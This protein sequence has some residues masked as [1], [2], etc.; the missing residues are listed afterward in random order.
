MTFGS[1]RL[2]F[3][4]EYEPEFPDRCAICGRESPGASYLSRILYPVWFGMHAL[5]I[6]R[7]RLQPRRIP[8]CTGC[9]R[10][11]LHS[12]GVFGW[13]FLAAIISTVFLSLF[14]LE[15]VVRVVVPSPWSLGFVAVPMLM[16]VAILSSLRWK[17]ADVV[18][19]GDTVE[20]LV[21]DPEYAREFDALNREHLLSAEEIRGKRARRW[22]LARA[23]GGRGRVRATYAATRIG[24]YREFLARFPARCVGC[25]VDAPGSRAAFQ[26]RYSG[27]MW[28]HRAILPN[29]GARPRV[30]CC[31][32]CLSRIQRLRF[33]R[34]TWTAAFLGVFAVF[35][36]EGLVREWI[37]RPWSMPFAAL[38]WIALLGTAIFSAPPI[39][40]TVR[41]DHVEY[42]FGNPTFAREFSKLNRESVVSR[43]PS[44]PS[45][46]PPAS[47]RE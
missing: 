5:V 4:R 3:P 37:P 14:L 25:G 16:G 39:E 47:F 23:W 31:A 36:L 33:V 20:Y 1:T 21:Y 29:L 2:E 19:C 10:A 18:V 27:W 12:D 28:F 38:S 6:R 13:L 34:G 32:S 24:I 15:P 22:N 26:P 44:D 7:D 11:V 8:A 43:D 9:V 41:A 40:V 45:D 30:P 46:G 17:P 35:V 42:A